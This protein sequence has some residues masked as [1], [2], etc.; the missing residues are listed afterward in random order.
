MTKDPVDY[1]RQ[2]ALISLAMI[3]IQQTDATNPKTSTVRKMYEKIIT[4]KHEDVMAKFGAVLGQGIIDAGGRNVTVSL[5]SRSGHANMTSIVGMAVFTQFWYWYPLT[6]FLSLSFMPTAIIGVNK[7]LQIPKFEVISNAKP[8]LFAYPPTT[9]PPTAVVVEKVATA[10]LSTTAKAKARAKKSEK[11]KAT[12]LMDVDERPPAEAEEKKKEE[13]KD[14]KKPKKKKEETFEVL[15]NMARV[16][17][18]QLKHITFLDESRY[19]PVKKGGG[20]LMLIDRRS[21]EKEELIAPSAPK[22]DG[23]SESKMEEEAAPFE[24]FEFPFDD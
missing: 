15:E 18:A 6:H 5:L 10:V 14:E 16:V 21:G 2:G 11:D 17:P 8:S 3:L 20:I 4:D 22:S 7:N 24:P 1:V 12:E 19:V 9:K 23:S 13:E